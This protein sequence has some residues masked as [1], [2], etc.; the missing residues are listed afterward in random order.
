MGRAVC[1]HCGARVEFF[2]DVCADC[3][4][5]SESDGWG[6]IVRAD[7]LALEDKMAREDY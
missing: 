3:G 1:R 4:P 7:Q 2:G 5:E 6:E